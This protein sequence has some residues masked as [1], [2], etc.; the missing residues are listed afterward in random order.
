VHGY[1]RQGT[2]NRGNWGR[3]RSVELSSGILAWHSSEL[4]NDLVSNWEV[5]CV[6]VHDSLLDVL[7]QL[8]K[9]LT[10]GRYIRNGSLWE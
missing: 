2:A 1:G 4:I 7:T 3:S 5:S 8:S 9:E 10:V 6:M